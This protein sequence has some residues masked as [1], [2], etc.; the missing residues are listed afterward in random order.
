M[1]VLDFSSYNSGSWPGQ[2]R[3]PGMSCDI[4]GTNSEIDLIINIKTRS[5]MFGFVNIASEVWSN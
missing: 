1:Y 4:Y 5:E 3:E 2:N